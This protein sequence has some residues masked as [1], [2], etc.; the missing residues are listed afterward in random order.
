VPRRVG[1]LAGLILLCGLYLVIA[2]WVTG[3]GGAGRLAVSSTVAGLALAL[4]AVADALFF[5]RMRG[6]FWVVPVIGAWVVVSPW[7]IGRGEDLGLT[8]TAWAG[9]AIAGVLVVLAGAMLVAPAFRR[10]P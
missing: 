8:A 10:S 6:I 9:N 7:V 4:L 5:A 1:A 2:P 3:F